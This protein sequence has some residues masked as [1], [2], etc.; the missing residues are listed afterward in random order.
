M[1]CKELTCFRKSKESLRYIARLMGSFTLRS[2]QNIFCGQ[3][4]YLN[5]LCARETGLFLLAIFLSIFFAH[6]AFDIRTILDECVYSSMTT[7]R[8]WS[9]KL[10]VYLW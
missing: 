5:C 2:Q 3:I 8:L 7:F 10:L 1:P 6:N 9:I 4:A